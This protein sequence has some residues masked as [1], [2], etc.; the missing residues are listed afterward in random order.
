MS[1]ENII[2][3]SAS[4]RGQGKFDEAIELIETN[5]DS[6][7]DDIKLN[8]YLEAFYAAEEKG[9]STQTK[10]YASLVANED[11]DVPSIQDY[12]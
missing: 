2:K 5:I 4:L 11:P 1:G 6:I 3:Q 8:A 12:L 9:D 7:D 10:K